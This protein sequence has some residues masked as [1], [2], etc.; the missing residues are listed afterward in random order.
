M[1]VIRPLNLIF[2]CIIF[3][4]LSYTTTPKFVLSFN[5][6]ICSYST[7]TNPAE[8]IIVLSFVSNDSVFS[9]LA[10]SKLSESIVVPVVSAIVFSLN[11]PVFNSIT[12]PCVGEN[13]K[14]FPRSNVLFSLGLVNA[15]LAKLAATLSPAYGNT[16]PID[17][18]YA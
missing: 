12:L 1:S 11:T 9:T 8:P 5:N 4:T 10:T 2:S 15:H 14:L 18:K 7:T 6:A 3:F 17:S 13:L 16:K